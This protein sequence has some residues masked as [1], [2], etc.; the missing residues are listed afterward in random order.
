MI[1][2]NVLTFLGRMHP[3]LVHL[4]IGFILLALLLDAI[5][6][7]PRYAHLRSAVPIALL[8]GFIAAVLA[9]ICGYLLS[10]SGDYDYK[11][12]THHKIAGIVM[13]ALSGILYLLT[14]PACKFLFRV[15]YRVFSVLVIALAGLLSYAGHLGGNLTHG[16]NYLNLQ[17][18]E[19]EVR[20]KPASTDEAYIFEDVVH[21]I[22]ISKCGQCHQ[23][24]KLKGN[25]S[26]ETLQSLLKGGKTGPAVVAGRLDQSELFR[27]IS[28]DPQDEKFMPAKGKT[29]LTKSEKAL[30]RWWIEKAHAV[31][32]KKV[33]EEKDKEA[34]KPQLAFYLGLEGAASPD[35]GSDSALV[36]HI[37]P[38]IPASLNP[39]LLDS[40]RQK[41][42]M[43]RLMLHKPV[44]L[45]ITLPAGSGKNM[46]DLKD[47]LKQVAKNIIWLDLSDNGLTEK[48]LDFL[49]QLSNLEK[50]R[51]EKN[52][53]SDSIS[54]ELVNLKHLQAVNL[55]E[56]KISNACLVAL[57][58]NTS[59][60]RVY[61]WAPGSKTAIANPVKSL[62]TE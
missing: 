13:T 30:I 44:M 14:T 27:R 39:K 28:L 51:L 4:P 24:G 16:T 45:D 31:E 7:I 40:L 12:L 36:Q 29:P 56:T 61:S 22:L 18:L 8:A 20:K 42:L 11:L 26:V 17:V 19:Q 2:L 46:A 1:L 32:G 57:Q 23:Q 34:I 9:C 60:K 35:E 37:N 21:P 33:G 55:T 49:P 59:I 58:K 43:V 54:G 48:D 10:L 62:K 52:P 25:L 6:Y 50:L 47:G 41:G 53:I 5:A 3:L 15:P 38:D